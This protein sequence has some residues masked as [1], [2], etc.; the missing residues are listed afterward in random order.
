M[1]ISPTRCAAGVTVAVLV[2]PAAALAQFEAT[3]APSP[4]GLYTRIPT[5]NDPLGIRVGAFYLFP[6]V[7]VA[8]QYSD[9]VFAEN[10]NKRSD[11]LLIVTPRLQVESNWTRHQLTLFAG[12]EFGIHNKFTGE[13]YQDYLLQA[14]FRG[15]ISDH[16][17]IRVMA[18][19]A[20][21]HQERGDPEE[22]EGLEPTIYDRTDA[23]V[24]L[25]QELGRLTLSGGAAF[26]RYDFEDTPGVNGVINNHD[27]NRNNYLVNGKAAFEFS[28]GYQVYA[29]FSY[30]WR[31]FIDPVD[32][33]GI[34]R[35]SQGYEATVGVVFELTNLLEGSL[36]GGY[37]SQ[38]PDDPQLTTISGAAFGA[39]LVWHPRKYLTV[40]LNADRGFEESFL[41]GATG[42]FADRAR[43]TVKYM[44]H[45]N[46]ELTAFGM[47]G[48]DDYHGITRNDT[49]YG[50]GLSASW[51]FHRALAAKVA[52]AYDRRTSNFPG[53]EDFGRNRVAVSLEARY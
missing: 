7:V 39:S 53:I 41:V 40:T 46:V 11:E 38:N 15:D 10:T 18:D 25:D 50:G 33:V 48:Q 45:S 6:S 51:R 42:Y 35:D 24:Q 14:N 16:T 30:D 27:R 17:K 19:H 43:L 21:D 44:I 34:N 36:Y 29:E 2:W 28:P 37:M 32:D 12:G 8:G 3:L 26:A 5:Y 23:R 52:Y 4:T 31:D 13:D 20:R 47:I 9:N 49:R 22:V 1:K